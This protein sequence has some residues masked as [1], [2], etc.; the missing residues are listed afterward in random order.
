[1]IPRIFLLVVCVVLLACGEPSPAATTA[2]KR[3]LQQI[4][5]APDARV[6]LC[7]R[8]DAGCDQKRDSVLRAC[9]PD[10]DC[11]LYTVRRERFPW[12]WQALQGP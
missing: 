10:A 5:S 11:Q 2:E 7:D 4:R 1:M 8:F 3:L 12:L 9:V 6:V